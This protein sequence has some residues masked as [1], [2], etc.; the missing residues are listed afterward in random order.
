MK[1]K[2]NP[3][4]AAF[5]DAVRMAHDYVCESCGKISPP[6]FDNGMIDNA[7]NVSRSVRILRY[8]PRNT[9]CLCRSCHM[10]MTKDPHEHV[11]FFKN[12]NGEEY[13]FCREMKNDNLVKLIKKDEKTIKL[14]YVREQTRILDMRMDG[15]TGEI[16]L[17][18]PDALT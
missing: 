16:E 14:H 11:G 2:R 12:L 1:T 13:E 7:H 17:N 15:V 18:I 10:R 9:A 6:P 3:T 5:S 8:D 4:D